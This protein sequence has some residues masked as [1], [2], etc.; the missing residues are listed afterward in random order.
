MHKK[1]KNKLETKFDNVVKLESTMLHANVPDHLTSGSEKNEDF[2][3]F[4]QHEPRREKIGF[5]QMR[6]QRRRSASR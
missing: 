4:R 3:R 1:N 6:K 2:Q 5:L